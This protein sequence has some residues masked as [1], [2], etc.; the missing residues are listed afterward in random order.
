MLL[1]TRLV[2]HW[3]RC[4]VRLTG[5]SSCLGMFTSCLD[6]AVEQPNLALKLAV[7]GVEGRLDLQKSLF[8]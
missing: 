7:L 5:R 8:I 6:Q 4:V 1:F 3:N 2:E